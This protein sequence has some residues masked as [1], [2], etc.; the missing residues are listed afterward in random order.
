MYQ[1]ARTRK[2][3]KK[4]HLNHRVWAAEKAA[5]RREI[6]GLNQSRSSA[7]LEFFDWE[8]GSFWFGASRQVERDRSRGLGWSDVVAVWWFPSQ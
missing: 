7:I 2:K 3:R 8:T 1:S 6:S 5:R 4:H